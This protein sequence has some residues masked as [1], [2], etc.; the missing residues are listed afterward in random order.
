MALPLLRDLYIFYV[1]MLAERLESLQMLELHLSERRNSDTIPNSVSIC[2]IRRCSFSGNGD[3]SATNIRLSRG[4]KL[5][6]E[7]KFVT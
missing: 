5:S 7:Q 1:L 6:T 3:W 4:V 2:C